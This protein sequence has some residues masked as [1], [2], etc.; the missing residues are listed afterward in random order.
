M[1][2]TGVDDP[3]DDVERAKKV[4]NH[5]VDNTCTTFIPRK[6]PNALHTSTHSHKVHRQCISDLEGS[7]DES[8]FFGNNSAFFRSCSAAPNITDKV[9]KF[10]RHFLNKLRTPM[11]TDRCYRSKRDPGVCNSGIKLPYGAEVVQQKYL[12]RYQLCTRSATQMAS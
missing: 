9:S 11:K 1:G 12:S 3:W 4:M 10:N 2:N 5:R 7:S 8:T 6:C